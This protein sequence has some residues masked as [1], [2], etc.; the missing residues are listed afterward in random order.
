MA[1][2]LLITKLQAPPQRAAL[3]AR[4][5]LTER[6]DEALRAGSRLLLVSAPAGYGKTTLVAEWGRGEGAAW[7]TLDEGDNGPVRFYAYL[8]AALRTLDPE[9]GQG[10]AE[11]IASPRP[12]AAPVLM[13][14]LIN[15]IALAT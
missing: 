8:I 12:P 10:A 1:D 2:P 5:R 9:L 15:D 4:R 3:V 7:L 6:L 13:T 11:L 14:S